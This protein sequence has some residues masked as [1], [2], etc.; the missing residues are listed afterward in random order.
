MFKVK[1]RVL[2]YDTYVVRVGFVSVFLP[3]A[4]YLVFLILTRASLE[5]EWGNKEI[6]VLLRSFLTLLMCTIMNAT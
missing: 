2:F 6:A 4:I 5:S 1:C 3:N